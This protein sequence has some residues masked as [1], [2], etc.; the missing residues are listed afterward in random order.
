MIHTTWGGTPAEAWTSIE[1]LK[2]VP[3]YAEIAEMTEKIQRDPSLLEQMRLDWYARHDPGTQEKWWSDR[4]DPSAW[5]EV[6][7]PVTMEASIRAGFDGVVWFR[8]TFELPA[9]AAG[10]SA[11]LD[12]GMIDDAD[13]T[14]L[15]GELIGETDGWTIPRHY[16]VPAGVLKAGRNVLAIRMLDTGGGGGWAEGSDPLQLIPAGENAPQPMSLA[17]T[18]RMKVGSPLTSGASF[19]ARG[20]LNQNSPAMLYNAMIHPI[21]PLPIKGVIWYQG[22][23]NNDRAGDYDE[24]FSAMISDWRARFDCGDFPFLYVQIAPHNQM[25]PELR[26]SQRLVLEQV[27]NTAM[28]VTTDVGDAGDIHPA[29][30]EP[31]GERLALAARALAYGEEIEYSGPLYA[32]FTVKADKAIIAFYAH[33]QWTDCQRRCIARF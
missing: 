30:K 31:V 29:R 27:P 17:G 1:Q 3:A 20:R 9:D 7:A 16:N 13:S 6:E 12:L 14:W 5:S 2:Q 8:R 19:Y 21:L 25:T 4:I 28:V 18:W 24:L 33:R 11:R 10:R 32:S 15:N 26:E 23:S 22:E